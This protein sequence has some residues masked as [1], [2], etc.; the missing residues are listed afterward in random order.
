M[1]AR[2]EPPRGA[3]A[4]KPARAGDNPPPH[5]K[6]PAPVGHKPAR[7]RKGPRPAP[8]PAPAGHKPPRH[9]KAPAP[10]ADR[11]PPLGTVRPRGDGGGT[12]Q[13][14]PRNLWESPQAKQR[15]AFSS[16]LPPTSKSGSDSKL[17]DAL[18]QA[19][20]CAVV[21]EADTVTHGFHSYP[22]RLHPSI[23]ATIL[24]AL[25]IAS[26]SAASS[27]KQSPKQSS[28]ASSKS[29]SS[30]VPAPF[31]VVDP[32][33][34]SGTVLIEARRRGLK[35]TGVDINPV[36][37]RVARVKTD[38]RDAPSRARFSA[39]LAE[40]VE[41]S[42]ERVR[43]RA[44]GHAPIPKEQVARYEGHVLRELAGLY[45]EIRAVHVEDD[46]RALE[47]VLSAIIVKVSKQRADTDV[48]DDEGGGRKMGRFIPTEIFHKK[49]RE[50]VERWSVFADECPRGSPSPAL[51]LEDARRLKDVLDAPADAIIT[52]PPY[53]GTYDYADHHAL[54]MPWLGLDDASL[55]AEIGARRNLKGERARDRWDDEVKTV[56]A[57][58]G[59]CLVDHGTAVLV[60]GDGE[61]ERVRVNAHEHIASLAPSVG[62]VVVAVA[63]APRLD[64]RGGADRHEHVVALRRAAA[65]RRA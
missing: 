17:A 8:G 7:H 37:L 27:P 29:S 19:L 6:A 44:P 20:E 41:K 23:A 30:V 10:P 25:V 34:G 40:V 53:A 35:A 21:D 62:L 1:A 60:V 5:K 47:V 54:R 49:G 48:R 39:T 43:D 63:S 52:S 9:D 64:W 18:F 12:D 57:S 14:S 32:F 65:P 61:I 51:F 56:L 4:G 50:L 28:K 42:K 45:E 38:V 59:R 11:R 55:R 15:R 36:A 3:G 13:D 16:V 24:D 26:V 22:A 2:R 46:R 31:H 33:C 58:L